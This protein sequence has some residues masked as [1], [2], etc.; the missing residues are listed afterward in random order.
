[1]MS[2]D[3]SNQGTSPEV[4]PTAA[5]E[6]S[7]QGAEPAKN[8]QPKKR[9]DSRRG[10]VSKSG[11]GGRLLGFLALLLASFAL[12]AV[13]WMYRELYLVPK[14]ADP[15][16]AQLAASLDNLQ[17]QQAEWQGRWESQRESLSQ[18]RS[19]QQRQLAALLARSQNVEAR[20][21]KLA[22]VD[23]KDWLIAEAEYLLR[24]ANQRL[25]LGRD[26]KAAAQLLS[27]AD[28]VLEEMDD[29]GLHKVRAELASEM[30]ALRSVA[31][32]DVE[33]I[34]L[35]LEGLGEALAKLTIFAVPSYEEDP[36][37]VEARAW[38]DKLASGFRRAWEKLR[39][40]IRIRH[41]EENFQPALAP[42][43]EA[44]LRY[45]L[46]LMI[47]QAQMALL[48]ERPELYRRSLQQAKEWL[49]KYYQ[50]NEELQGQL[51]SLDDLTAVPLSREMPD[52]SASLEALKTY[53]D[54]RRWQ[55]EVNG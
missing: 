5:L 40:Y 17:E 22:T 50:L 55:Q 42:E 21:D 32:F 3:K 47:E 54:S 36:V 44:A 33:G 19:D 9:S 51:D 43:Q 25:Q 49:G 38:Q 41:R 24:L 10:T 52:I 39:S 6:D 35:R 46:Q 2:G 20:V 11:R 16:I 14:A 4:A 7:A 18:L 53:I 27:S 13:A 34:Y 30:A 45:S 26:A 31:D 15:A 28:Q 37:V 12:A 1:M 48:A 23:R 8:E 29:T